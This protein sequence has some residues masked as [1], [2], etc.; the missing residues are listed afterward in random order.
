MP[1]NLPPVL[2]LLNRAEILLT[3]AYKYDSRWNYTDDL[4]HITGFNVSVIAIIF[5][6][7]MFMFC[8]S[9]RA[10]EGDRTH[11]LKYQRVCSE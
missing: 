11:N 6:I 4:S 1:R 5:P 10:R 7:H 2:V 3:H 9:D 8:K